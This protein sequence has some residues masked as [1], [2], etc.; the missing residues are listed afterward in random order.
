[1]RKSRSAPPGRRAAQ[2][3][4]IVRLAETAASPTQMKRRFQAEL[5]QALSISIDAGAAGRLSA[6][7]AQVLV[8]AAV[9]AKDR[10]IALRVTEASAPF[11]ASMEDLGLGD[12]LREHDGGTRVPGCARRG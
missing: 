3:T 8:A 11:L 12:W 1:M 4:R 7:Q 10:G 6:A 9:S 5:K 2:A